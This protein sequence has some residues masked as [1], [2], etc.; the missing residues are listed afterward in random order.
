MSIQRTFLLPSLS[1]IA[2]S[3]LQLANHL[4]LGVE[5]FLKDETYLNISE[6]LRTPNITA[7]TDSN[8]PLSTFGLIP[9][10]LMTDTWYDL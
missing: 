3:I 10:R 1:P 5:A 2:G 7:P 6:L 4:R 9:V 8:F